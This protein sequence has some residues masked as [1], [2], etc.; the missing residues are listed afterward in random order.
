MYILIILN[1]QTMFLIWWNKYSIKQV[2]YVKCSLCESIKK[3]YVTQY[4]QNVTNYSTWHK[5]S[6][7]TPGLA[8]HLNLGPLKEISMPIIQV[9]MRRKRTLMIFVTSLKTLP[10][11]YH[12]KLTYSQEN[13]VDFH[14]CANGSLNF[15]KNLQAVINNQYII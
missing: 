1:D 7:W 2:S 5:I 15:R 3:R 8:S 9:W 6:Q 4:S 14:L 13:K 10:A 12:L 11:Q